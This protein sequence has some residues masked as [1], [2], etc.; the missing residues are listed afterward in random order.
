MSAPTIIVTG[1]AGFI[2]SHTCKQLALSGYRPVAVDNLSTGH[3]DAVKWGPLEQVDIRDAPALTALFRREAPL[4]V[5]HF[6]ASAYVGESVTDPALYYDN[7]V[8]GMI[9]L[10][11]ACTETGIGK[12]VFSSS[13]ATYGIPAANPITEETPQVPIN[14]YGQTKLIC[15]H[16]LRDYGAAFGLNSVS[17]RYF[18]AAGA[19]PDGELRERHT[20]ETHLIPLALMATA[21]RRPPLDVFGTDYPT[22]DGTCIRDYIHVADLAMA[23][24]AALRHLE[25]GRGSV[26]LNLGT[27]KGHSILEIAGEIEKVVGRPLPWHPRTASRGRPA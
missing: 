15:E 6:A 25:A 17:L 12:L 9:S 21:G 24:V 2:G 14:P 4:A 8:G 18:N 5:V 7:N 10:L 13:C 23:H 1:G 27:G 19:D 26:A 20:P 11:K 3:A 22:P 16:M